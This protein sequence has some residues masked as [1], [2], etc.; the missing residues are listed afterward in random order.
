MRDVYLSAGAGF[1]V[2]L[3][4]DIMT[5]PGLPKVL[6]A[7]SIDIDENGDIVGLS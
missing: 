3:S 5:M 4:G 2:A 7:D 6:A 1:M